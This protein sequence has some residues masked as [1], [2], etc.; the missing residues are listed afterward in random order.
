MRWGR[1]GAQERVKGPSKVREC[2]MVADGDNF[3]AMLVDV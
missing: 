3:P 1:D 2:E